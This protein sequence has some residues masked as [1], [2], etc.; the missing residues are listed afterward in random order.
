M[1]TTI[2]TVS[3]AGKIF[4]GN[5][6][7]AGYGTNLDYD[8]RGLLEPR[9]YFK[10]Y[11]AIITADPDGVC[12]SQ[13]ASGAHTLTINGA[14]ATA[15]VAT[16]DVPRNVTIDSGGADTAVLTITGTD[17]YGY[18]MSEAIT[19]NGTTEV[20]G[21]KAFKTIT[22]VTSSATIS[23]GAFVGSGVIIG[24][25]I[26]LQNKSDFINATLDGANSVPTL[27]AAVSTDPATTTTGDVRGTVQFGTAPNDTRVYGVL[28]AISRENG[29]AAGFGVTQA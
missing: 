29:R 23:N 9:L 21:K 16:F 1:A 18:T 7:D 26:A 28:Y 11:G 6:Y 22:S 15:G 3:N 12:Q 4:S 27:V 14:L 19:L 8:G 5:N 10:N 2:H 24:L 13:S 17:E 20:V 25:P